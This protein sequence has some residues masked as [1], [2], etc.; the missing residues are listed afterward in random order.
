MLKVIDEL[1]VPLLVFFLASWVLRR[2]PEGASDRVTAAPGCRI[3]PSLIREAFEVDSLAKRLPL[4][5]EHRM[6]RLYF[7]PPLSPL[8][9]SFNQSL[10][11]A[12]RDDIF[13]TVFEV[14][15]VEWYL[16]QT[17]RLL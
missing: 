13:V 10:V 6:D 12:I 17:S 3:V 7:H 9:R 5:V 11:V 14:G 16:A 8:H 15:V 2:L 4:E 1:S